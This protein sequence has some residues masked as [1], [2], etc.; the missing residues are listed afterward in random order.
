MLQESAILSTFIKLPFV[1]KTFVLSIFEW[2]LKTGFTVALLFGNQK[3]TKVPASRESTKISCADSFFFP[4]PGFFY[5]WGMVFFVT[6]TLVWILKREHPDPEVDPE[7]GIVE[8]YKQ[9]YKVIRLPAVI[10][11][12]AILLT[13]KVIMWQSQQKS[14]AFLVC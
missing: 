12:T 7:H 1:F 3:T 11:Y 6:T 10:S 2:S 14:S 13:S 4:S 8:T 9:L 5:F